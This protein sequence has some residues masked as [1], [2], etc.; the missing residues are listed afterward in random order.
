MS[1]PGQQ[2]DQSTV[3]IVDPNGW[4]GLL[5]L[6]PPTVIGANTIMSAG[7]W[8]TWIC[9]LTGSRGGL[10][11]ISCLHDIM[12]WSA[13]DL[14]DAITSFPAWTQENDYAEAMLT[15]LSTKVSSQVIGTAVFTG[16]TWRNV[17][18]ISGLNDEQMGAAA[19]AYRR[20]M[21]ELVS[22]LQ[23]IPPPT[24]RV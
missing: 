7:D 5:S 1:H 11:Q 2:A 12:C 16:F 17:N 21:R 24:E 19:S 3:F 22:S 14:G 20:S 15:S 8:E 23:P 10:N 4:Y 13:A 6:R 18:M 9:R